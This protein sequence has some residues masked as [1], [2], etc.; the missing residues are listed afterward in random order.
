MTAGSQIVRDL[1]RALDLR[2]VSEGMAMLDEG[3]EIWTRLVPSQAHAAE[4]L[5]LL[6]QWIDI[7]YRDYYLLDSLLKKYPAGSRR[8]LPLEDYLRL[9]MVEAFRAFAAEEVDPAIETLDFV[10]R[11]ER[12]AEDEQL[13]TLAFFWKGRAHRKK[14]EY[15]MALREIV[16]ARELAHA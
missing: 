5:L 8:R 7:G 16:S 13:M 12:G 3:E 6:A 1:N 14:G 15:E 9:R 2:R 10:L 11:A 4:L